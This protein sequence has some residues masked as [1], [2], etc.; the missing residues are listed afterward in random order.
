MLPGHLHP[1]DPGWLAGDQLVPRGV[2]GQPAGRVCGTAIGIA[3]M[4]DA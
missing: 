2:R 4:P 3:L 1:A